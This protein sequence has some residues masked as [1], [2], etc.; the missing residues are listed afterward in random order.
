MES[1]ASDLPG[2]IE[3]DEDDLPPLDPE[4]PPLIEMTEEDYQRCEQEYGLS[5]SYHSISS[6][7]VFA[8]ITKNPLQNSSSLEGP[9][10]LH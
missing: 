4:M 3:S 5:V 2:L 1:I 6:V 9:R 10:K 8:V 7:S